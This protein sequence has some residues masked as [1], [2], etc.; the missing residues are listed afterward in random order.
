M[1]GQFPPR[2]VAL[3]LG[4]GFGLEL[5][6]RLGLGQF[7]SEIII[8]EP[9]KENQITVIFEI[10]FKVFVENVTKAEGTFPN[11]SIYEKKTRNEGGKCTVLFYIV[12]CVSL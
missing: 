6:L 3:R 9:I 5:M 11:E 8:L 4:L 1:P 10:N 2:K 12:Y 7:S